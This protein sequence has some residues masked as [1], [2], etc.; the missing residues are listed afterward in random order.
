MQTYT[1]TL[2]GET[3]TRDFN[4]ILRDRDYYL[5]STMQSGSAGTNFAEYAE[6]DFT[7]MEGDVLDIFA[8]TFP[9]T[10][11]SP[12]IVTLEIPTGSAMGFVNPY[13]L[14]ITV[15]GFT[16]GLSAP[17]TG[18]I[19]YKA[20]YS[21][22]YPAQVLRAPRFPSTTV[23]ASAGTVSIASLTNVTM[24]FNPFTPA[25]SPTEFSFTTVDNGNDQSDTYLE[26]TLLVSNAATAELSAEFDGT[27]DYIALQ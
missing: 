5:I 19:V 9:L 17:P 1:D 22:V 13:I 23:N 20:I 2:T 24:S 12:P 15:T 14:N 8:V 4:Q 26:E 7:P 3:R 10:F 18:T 16:F 6:E 27:V 11:S 21:S 25:L